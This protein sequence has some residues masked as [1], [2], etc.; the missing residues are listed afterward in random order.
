MIVDVILKT[1]KLLKKTTYRVNQFNKVFEGKKVLP[2][3]T[4]GIILTCS[5]IFCTVSYPSSTLDRQFTHLTSQ[6]IIPVIVKKMVLF[7]E[8]L[9]TEPTGE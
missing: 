6:E 7:L 9:Y 2:K 3:Q 4:R 5:S 1:G 8:E